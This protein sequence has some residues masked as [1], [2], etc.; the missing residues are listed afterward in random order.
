MPYYFLGECY[1]RAGKVSD[2]RRVLQQA[3]N[4]APQ[5]PAAL[6]SLAR[7]VKASKDEATA[8]LLFKRHAK[9]TSLLSEIDSLSTRAQEKPDDTGLVKQ[10]TRTQ[11]QLNRLVQQPLPDVPKN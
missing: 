11:E 7:A 3:V 8:A 6:Y 1:L 10:L 9:L 5:F 2:A 4:M